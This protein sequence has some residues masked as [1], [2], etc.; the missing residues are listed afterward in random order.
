MSRGREPEHAHGAVHERARDSFFA[1]RHGDP[2]ALRICHGTSCRLAG[3]ARHQAVLERAEPVRRI[4]C[5]GYCDRSPVALQPDGAVVG[6][7]ADGARVARESLAPLPEIRTRSRAAV[8]TERIARGEF[9]ALASARA[10]GVWSAFERALRGAPES[11]LCALEASGERGRGGAGFPTAAKWRSAARASSD[12]RFAIANGDEGDPGSFVDRVLLEADPHAVLEG[13]ALCGF[14]I[15][16]RHGI[17]YVRAEYPRAASR[18]EA[19]IAEARAAGLLG[20]HVLGSDFSFEVRVARGEGSYVCGEETA[21][22]NALEGRRG[23]VRLRPPH[24]SERGLHGR[25]TVVNNVE[26][27]VNAAWIA[28]NGAGAYRALGTRESSGTKALS[29]SAG[30]GRP[31]IVEVEFGTSLADVIEGAAG[32]AALAAVALGGPMGSVLL[33]DEWNV[34]IAFES[35]RERGLELGHGGLVALPSDTDFRALA[36][37]WLEFMAEESCGKCVPCR[38]GSARALELARAGERER[39]LELLD[40]VSAASL[41]AFGQSIPAPVRK[42]LTRLAPAPGERAP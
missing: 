40:V 4:Y 23:E 25:P 7:R 12:E 24:P 11:V 27:L 34:P 16:A 13:L 14:A 5:A 41:C 15:G 6:L 33:A 8:V 18:I 20:S 26:T 35:L 19:A 29:L 28:R 30:F 1:E 21:L 31:G 32:G 38:V 22:L 36:S 37:D 42:I 10:A 3:A 17:V 39:L 2:A 9:H